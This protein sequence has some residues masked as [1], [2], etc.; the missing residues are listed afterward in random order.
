MKCEVDYCKKSRG[1]MPVKD[2]LDDLPLNTKPWNCNI[3][4]PSR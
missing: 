2:F 4:L 3:P 1:D